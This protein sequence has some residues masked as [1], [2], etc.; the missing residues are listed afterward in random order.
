METCSIIVNVRDRFSAMTA[1]LN[2][3][4][5]HTPPQHELIVVAGGAPRSL[6][7]AWVRDFG[8]RVRF[9]FRPDFLN[10]AQAR[11]IGLRAATTRLAVVMDNDVYVR[12]RWLEPL[13]QCQADTEAVMVVPL[14]L[15]AERRIHTAGQELY[16][17]YE[18]GKAFGHK[19]SRCH[20]LTFDKRCNL[21]RRRTDYGELHCQLVV[22]EPTLRLGA[23]D[24][25]I[26]EVGEVDSGLTWAAAG[27]EMWVEPESV[28]LYAVEELLAVEDIRLFEWRWDMRAIW[29]GYEYFRCKWGM[30]ITGHG[31]FRDHLWH[32]H[33]RLGLLPRVL[34]CR[35]ALQVD[36]ALTRGRTL[37]RWLSAPLRA[38]AIVLRIYKARRIG[39]YA[40]PTPAKP[41]ADH[42]DARG[43]H[44]H[45]PAAPG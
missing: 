28:V 11:N 35:L 8:D 42:E 14:I 31:S 25:R 22:V 24:E 7:G 2:A 1:C 19:A 41:A 4:M 13:I 16:I 3:L 10:Q 26:L 17:T 29:D 39:Y 30:D 9:L 6:C 27:H 21:R 38:P 5:A 40:W 33:R 12:S 15:E 45:L 34:P 43:G 18:N 23:Y 36:H 20:G 37:G 44:G 32:Y